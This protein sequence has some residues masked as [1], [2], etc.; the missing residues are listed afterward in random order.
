MFQSFWTLTGNPGLL[1]SKA[2]K[3]LA[4]STGV[5]KEV[6]LYAL[7]LGLEG[8]SVLDGTTDGRHM[9]E[10]LEG[11]EMVDRWAKGEGEDDW[12]RILEEFK[13]A[14]GEVSDVGI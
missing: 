3:E 11:V 9:R 5:S 6:A 13:G 10:D 8:V 7:V 1:E 2:V 14:I 4:D 12:R